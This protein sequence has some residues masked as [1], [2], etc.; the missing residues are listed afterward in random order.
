MAKV[1]LGP[2]T[3]AYPMPAFLVGASV[4]GKPNFLTVAWGGIACAEPPMVAVA[5][6]HRRYTYKGIKENGTFSVN[7]PSDKMVVATDYCGIV[8]G[9]KA[10]KVKACGFHVFYGALKSAPLIEE[11]PLNLECRVFRVDDLG[12][13]ALVVGEIVECHVS[14]ECLTGGRPDASKIKPLIYSEGPQAQY[15]AFGR[16]LGRAFSVGRRLKATGLD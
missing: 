7:V 10:D 3:L 6:R 11:C 12:S 14:E 13:H 8:S 15:R 2:Q 9:L 4:G 1:K 5:L 16:V